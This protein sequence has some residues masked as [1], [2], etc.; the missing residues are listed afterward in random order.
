MSWSDKRESVLLHDFIVDFDRII[1]NKC[2]R[3]KEPMAFIR[4]GDGEVLVAQGKSVNVE[5]DDWSSPSR[6]TKLGEDIKAS[7]IYCDNGYYVGIPC[8]CEPRLQNYCLAFL[9][10]PSEQITFANLLVNGNYERW[11]QAASGIDEPVVYVGNERCDVSKLPFKVSHLHPVGDK[12]VEYWG[13]GRGEEFECLA[14]SHDNTLFMVSAGPMSEPII[15]KMWM[16]NKSN[17]YLDVGST[18]NPYTLGLKNRGYLTGTGGH[19]KKC[20][21]V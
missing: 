1:L 8:C 2:L 17:R 15:H 20:R 4:I 10:V 5:R 18:F 3:D 9:N 11:I 13:E 7:M 6:L 19:G 21:F 14:K 12:C 16:A